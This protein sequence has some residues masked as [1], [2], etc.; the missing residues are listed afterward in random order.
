MVVEPRGIDSGTSRTLSVV[1]GFADVDARKMA[2]RGFFSLN[3]VRRASSKEGAMSV[4][5]AMAWLKVVMAVR[6]LVE[7]VWLRRA[8]GASEI[9]AQV[10]YSVVACLSLERAWPD[11]R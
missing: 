10:R 1:G 11:L 3:K 6:P 2:R 9:R 7:L 5:S 8:I 4:T